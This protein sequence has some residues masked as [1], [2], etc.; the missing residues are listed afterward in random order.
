MPLS[1]LALLLARALI[2]VAHVPVVVALLPEAARLEPQAAHTFRERKFQIVHGVGQ[3]VLR[4][5]TQEQVDVLGHHHLSVNAHLET[6]THVFE[7]F[8][9]AIEEFGGREKGLAMVATESD[10]VRLLGVV[11]T[12]ETTRH[13]GSYIRAAV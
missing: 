10:K 13:E 3:A 12:L 1:L 5:L 9:E 4:R 11:E 6:A 7:S 2:E 8:H